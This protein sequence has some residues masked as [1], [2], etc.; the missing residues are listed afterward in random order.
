MEFRLFYRGP[1]KSNGSK[2]HKHDIRRQ[3]HP[4]LRNLWN[5][6]PLK[7]V[8]PFSLSRAPE[9]LKAS[10]YVLG[11]EQP[12]WEIGNCRFFP[13]VRKDFNLIA[14]LEIILLRPEEP[15]AIITQGGD[16]DNRLKTLFDA[17]RMPTAISELPSSCVPATDENPLFYCLLQDDALITGVSVVTDRLLSVCE[18]EEVIL[19]VKTRITGTKSIWINQGITG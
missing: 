7:D 1:L 5:Q 19:L 18:G 13:L 10:L 2:E 12:F 3:F 4:Q 11:I 16:I 6:S 8:F 9:S 15:G 14:Q 17:L